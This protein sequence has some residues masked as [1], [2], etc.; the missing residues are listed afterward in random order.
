M[1]L[2]EQD[3]RDGL[4]FLVGTWQVDYIVNAFSNDLAHIPA[5]EF[6]STDGTDFTSI[7][8]E[9]F[10]DHTLVLRNAANGREIK[11]TWEQTGWSEYHYT[12]EDFYDIPDDNFRK[13]AETLQVFDGCIVFSIGFLAIG[14]KKIAEGTVT[15][16]KKQ[17]IGDVEMT[18]DDQKCKD[19]VGTYRAAKMMSMIGGSFELFTVEEILADLDKQLAAGTIDEHEAAQTKS[20]I[21]ARYE[22]TEDHRVLEK[23]KVPDGVGEDEIKAAIEAGEIKDYKDGYFSR[24][25]KQWKAVGGKYYYDTQEQRELFGEAQSSWD[26]LVFDEDGLLNYGSGFVKLKKSE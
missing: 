10:E 9:F 23:M 22:F 3:L 5:T 1:E 26:E 4:K 25:E 7:T 20:L 16:Q 21:D 14:M 18:E 24:G 19:I 8:Y 17:D 15:V 11:G 13:G 12:V 2:D 6:K